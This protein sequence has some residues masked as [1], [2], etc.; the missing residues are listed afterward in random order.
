MGAFFSRQRQDENR[1]LLTSAND[2]D[3]RVV[4]ITPQSSAHQLAPDVLGV[5]SLCLPSQSFLAFRMVCKKF[6]ESTRQF[7]SFAPNKE[8]LLGIQSRLFGSL[9]ILHR[10][11]VTLFLCDIHSNQ[12]H[13]LPV[14]ITLEE[15]EL[16][17]PSISSNNNMITKNVIEKI[18]NAM[19][20]FTT[21]SDFLNSSSPS[22]NDYEQSQTYALIISLLVSYLILTAA[23]I[24]LFIENKKRSPGPYILAT[25]LMLVTIGIPCL[26]FSTMLNYRNNTR[27]NTRNNIRLYYSSNNNYIDPKLTPLRAGV[28]L[29]RQYLFVDS[30][31]PRD[32]VERSV[33]S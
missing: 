7:A 33:K 9:K 25:L 30:N 31:D 13:Y 27:N 14:G 10:D 24:M 12:T 17:K 5:I 26:L 11:Q 21:P 15:L 2:A 32:N 23:G 28:R 3:T 16:L 1:P 22:L 29:F 18:I 19:E 4:T 6:L 20:E 8:F